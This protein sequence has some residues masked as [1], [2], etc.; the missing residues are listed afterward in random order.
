[1]VLTRTGLIF[2]AA[3]L[4]QNHVELLHEDFPTLIILKGFLSSVFS[5]MPPQI[6][7]KLEGL[8]TLLALQELLCSVQLLPHE[9]RAV[10]EA[11][12]EAVTFRFMP[13]C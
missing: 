7:G 11:F 3:P 13:H 8:L 9:V 2:L 6:G 4:L 10:A 5:Q 1:M 12:S